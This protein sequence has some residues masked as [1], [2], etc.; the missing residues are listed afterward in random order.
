MSTKTLR[1]STRRLIRDYD[2]FQ[3]SYPTLIRSSDPL[4]NGVNLQTIFNDSKTLV[5]SSQNIAFPSM[6]PSGSSAL[7]NSTISAI[8][9]L[10]ASAI[11]QRPSMPGSA[12]NLTPFNELTFNL[13]AT[14]ENTSS[15][16]FAPG[17][18]IPA[19]NKIAIPVDI[20]SNNEHYLFRLNFSDT[21]ADPN[22]DFY[23]KASTGFCYYNF[24]ERR[25]EDI[26]LVNN[27]YTGK[28]GDA[29]KADCTTIDGQ[30]YFM[31]QFVGTPNISGKFSLAT[32]DAISGAFK[33]SGYDK[34]GS[35]TEFFDAPQAARYYATASQGLNLSNYIQ[36]PFYLERI[37]VKIPIVARRKHGERLGGATDPYEAS[38]RDIDNLV[39]FMYRQTSNTDPLKTQRFL[40]AHESLSFYNSLINKGLIYTTHN[41][42]FSHD[43]KL[44]I[45]SSAEALFTGSVSFSMYPKITSPNFG[46]VTAHTFLDTASS[47]F[48]GCNI[49][50]YWTGPMLSA[51]SSSINTV[52]GTISNVDRNSFW[53]VSNKSEPDIVFESSLNP[54]QRFLIN[55]ATGSLLPTA[56]NTNISILPDDVKKLN[57]T[58]WSQT[59]MPYLLF[60]TDQL[61]LGLESDICSKIRITGNYV[62]GYDTSILSQ[63]SSFFKVLTDEAKITLYGSLVQNGVAK[64][65]NSINQN[66][67]SP[68]IHEIISNTQDD[69]DQFDIDEKELFVGTYLDNFI[70]GSITTNTR[71]VAESIID[72][73]Q[74][75]SG[76]FIRS[77]PLSDTSKTYL[78]KGK[79]VVFGLIVTPYSDPKYP[80]NY[81]RYNRYGNFRDM[82]EQA[83][84]YRIFNKTLYKKSGGFEEQGP[85]YAQFVLSSSDIPVSA[86]LTQC[87]N[88]SP[89]MT[90]TLPFDDT[91]SGSL[92]RGPYPSPVNNNPFMPI[93]NI[94]KT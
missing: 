23:G 9:N 71:G 91:L 46:G 92:S 31:S 2:Q 13:P 57:S 76:S 21:N 26:G 80:K 87:N 42:I 8:L 61:V 44:S 62:D 32:I 28:L 56:P 39:F 18:G 27:S 19:R 78:Q 40:I 69:S 48:K 85:V 10:N 25:W 29:S 64:T 36:Q 86:S 30:N 54:D 75:L 47:K 51:L 45:S 20:T 82:L 81:F 3:Q 33:Y 84:D 4:N 67:I 16:V 14:Y 73:P 34:I 83:R 43:Y 37:D 12:E 5:F 89:Y 68:A 1:K 41:P 72:G 93:T 79:S 15:I 55:Y 22:G 74:I 58:N 11:E 52:S 35:P 94:F 7:P 53:K 66:L 17:F 24:N 6:T 38:L 65:S 90:G 63:T 88:L 70:T 60:P 59:K 49:L 77:L 50:N